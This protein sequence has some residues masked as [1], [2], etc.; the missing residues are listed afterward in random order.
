[1]SKPIIPT[2]YWWA[3]FKTPY[4]NTPFHY[5]RLLGFA[6]GE[7]L[8]GAPGYYIEG[9]CLELKNVAGIANERPNFI[10]F[11]YSERD[12]TTCVH[13]PDDIDEVVFDSPK[14]NKIEFEEM[15]KRLE[16]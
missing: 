6:L 5:V 2:Q 10:R 13:N 15:L 16:K 8:Y 9:I 3:V 4:P 7:Q 1:M 14:M 11:L 12:L